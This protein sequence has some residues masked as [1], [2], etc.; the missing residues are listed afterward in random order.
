M[1]AAFY[2]QLS[3]RPPVDISICSRDYVL[4]FV[5]HSTNLV[6]EVKRSLSANKQR[7][8]VLWYLTLDFPN[9]REYIRLQVIG[10]RS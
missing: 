10:T 1:L 2:H 8:T 9:A 6:L 7:S 5:C 4:G 3:I